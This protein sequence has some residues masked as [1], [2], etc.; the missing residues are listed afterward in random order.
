MLH[1]A[2]A[3]TA[4]PEKIYKRRLSLDIKVATIQIGMTSAYVPA[5]QMGSGIAQVAAIKG[6]EVVLCDTHKGALEKSITSTARSFNRMVMKEKLTQEQADA[7][8]QRVRTST[9]LEVF[10][11]PSLQ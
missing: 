3:F 7:A 10:P 11:H 6:L 9:D 4:A 5:G 2:C 8:A 1:L